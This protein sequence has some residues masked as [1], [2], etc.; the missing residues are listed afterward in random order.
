M[1][2]FQMVR[3]NL[4]KNKWITITEYTRHA[5]KCVFN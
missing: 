4:L 1:F 2:T 5:C 3:E